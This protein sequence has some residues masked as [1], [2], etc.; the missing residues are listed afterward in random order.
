MK[1]AGLF[2]GIGGFE[3][4]LSASGHE[5]SLLCDISSPAQA[6]LHRRFPG[7]SIVGDVRTIDA[8]PGDVELVCAGFPCQDLS[9]AGRTRGLDG[10]NS[11]LVREVFR[12]IAPD[13][14][15][16]VVIENVPFMLQLRGGAAMRSIVDELER[17]GFRWAYRVVDTFSFGLP[18]RRERVFLVGARDMD[19]ADV[20]LSDENKIERP[21]TDLSRL[22]H[23]FYWTEGRGGLGW[24][25]DS[26]PT[27]KNG[28]TIGIPSPPAILFP[29]GSIVKPD[30]R[31]GERLQGFPED[32]TLPAI[33]VGK[34][35]ARWSLV[36][37]AVSVPVA[38]WL[39][40]MLRS[41]GKYDDLRDGR[42]AT[43]GKL[44]KAARFDGRRR[45][46]VDI[47]VDPLGVV[48]PHLSDFLRHPGTPLTAKATR[49]FL[50]RTA[51][52]KLRFADGFIEAV[53]RHLDDVSMKHL[54]ARLEA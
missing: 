31:D 25:V 48:P 28:S 13:H 33:D 43:E 21:A 46:A 44:P 20:I 35:S 11:G 34:A 42:F 24:A 26:V 7:V 10:D 15:R 40:T 18:Q 2:A 4:G 9:Q 22:A 32:W 54:A 41:P 3:L 29:D 52:A 14:V 17:L 5:T 19:P 45:H 16:T 51:V 6:V 38:R 12:L 47:G 37:S 1:A 8:L 39:G 36:G 49:G 27:L 23:G 53:K 50:S 30:V